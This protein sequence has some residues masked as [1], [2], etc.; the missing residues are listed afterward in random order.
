MLTADG[1]GSATS[2]GFRKTAGDVE[3]NLLPVFRTGGLKAVVLIKF[4][5]VCGLSLIHI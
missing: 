2:D 4:Y 1:E 3:I 5:R